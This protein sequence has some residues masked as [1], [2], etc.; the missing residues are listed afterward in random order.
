MPNI[1][2]IAADNNNYGITLNVLKPGRQLLKT[3]HRD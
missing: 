1:T 3:L 2:F